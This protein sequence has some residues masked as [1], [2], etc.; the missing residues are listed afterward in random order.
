METPI[1]YSKDE[2]KIRFHKR[3]NNE[4]QIAISDD[5]KKLILPVS[6]EVCKKLKKKLSRFL[7]SVDV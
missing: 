7:D 3:G 5:E 6:L 4:V 1:F 2:T